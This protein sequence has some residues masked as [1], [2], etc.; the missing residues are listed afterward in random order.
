M[1]CDIVIT[2]LHAFVRNW[3]EIPP[4]V[5]VEDGQTEIPLELSGM[6]WDRIES[7]CDILW[8]GRENLTNRILNHIEG[9]VDNVRVLFYGQDISWY[10]ILLYC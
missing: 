8:A 5:P 4:G 1:F 6:Y 2:C 9:L 7:V 10:V 3:N